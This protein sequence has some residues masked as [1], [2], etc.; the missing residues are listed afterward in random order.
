M[1]IEEKKLLTDIVIA[2]ASIDEH[3][4]KRRS[5]E[6]HKQVKQKEEL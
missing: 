5:F 6:E 2:I 3:L 1:I 4:E